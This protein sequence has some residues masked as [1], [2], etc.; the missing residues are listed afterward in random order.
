MPT[1]KSD[2]IHNLTTGQRVAL[3]LNN[4]YREVVEGTISSITPHAIRV[5]TRDRIIS[6][7]KDTEFILRVRVG[8]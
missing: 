6:V 1:T 7:S 5:Q 4:T 2:R 8:A 3:T